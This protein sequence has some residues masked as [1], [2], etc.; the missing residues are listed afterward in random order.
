MYLSHLSVSGFRQF[1][2]EE[3]SVSLSFN[4]GVTALIGKNDSGKTAIIDAIRY[5]LT[6]R[7]QH[8]IAI[9]RDDFHMAADGTQLGNIDITC[10]LSDLSVAEQGAFAEYLTIDSGEVH[11][12]VNLSARRLESVTAG[13]RWVDVSVRAGFEGGGPALETSVKELLAVTYLRPLRDAQRE[14]SSGRGSRLSQILYHV[15][16]INDGEQFDASTPPQ[17]PEG[18]DELSILGL[19]TY[20]ANAIKSHTGI[21]N[22]ELSINDE[23]LDVL[24]LAGDN[25]RGRIDLTEGGTDESRLRQILERLQIDLE[26]ADSKTRRGVSG[27]GSSNILYMACELLLLGR[28]PEGLPLLLVEEPE[29]H[30]HPQRQIRLMRFLKEPSVRSTETQSKRNVQVILSTHSPNLASGLPVENTVLFDGYSAFSLSESHTKLSSSDYSFLDR[31]L[32]V[33]KANLFFANGVLIVEGDGESLLIPAL[34]RAIG[35]DLSDFGVSVVNVR[36]TGLKRFSRIFQRSSSTT[37]LIN[38]PVACVADLDVMP[39]RAPELL[40]IVSGDKDPLWQSTKRRWK[41][42]RDFGST[43]EEQSE[44]LE[45]RNIKLKENDSQHVKTFVADHWTLE[46][47]L[48]RCGMAKYV[49]E[50]AILAKNHEQLCTDPSLLDTTK[51]KATSDFEAILK[52]HKEDAELIAIQVYEQ[53]RNKNVSKSIAAQYLAEIIDNQS[54]SDAFDVIHF[55]ATLPSYLVEAVHHACQPISTS[56]AVPA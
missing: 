38:I 9:Q 36:G 53:F 2:T 18:I 52:E 51:A 29:A 1:G 19:S 28:E 56:S 49:Y 15:K 48:A 46:Y 25:L 24:L 31:F 45:Q 44:A 3:N 43:P 17:N 50:A 33:T 30:L 40:G 32:D 37:K 35:F 54:A 16:G 12:I 41:A 10:T 42:V 21:Q 7:D 8:Y 6:S 4:P 5:A 27:L 47:D 14:L 20:F 55:Q 39:D 22:A 11:F 34:A 13:R 23:L 26:H